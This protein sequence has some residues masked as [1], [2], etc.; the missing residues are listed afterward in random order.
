M[1]PR[2]ITPGSIMPAYAHLVNERV[3]LG[4]T[5]DKVRAM[6]TLGVPYTDAQIADAPAAAR[7]AGAAIVAELAREG[8]V[9]LDAESKMVA[10]IAYVQRLGKRTSPEN[11]PA[12]EATASARTGV[13]R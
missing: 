9:R 8:H 5:P 7:R 10:L 2:Q 1:D 11:A 12:P 6:Q 13:T 4:R 3:D